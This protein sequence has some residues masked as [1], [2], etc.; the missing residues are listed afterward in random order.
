MSNY[1]DFLNVVSKLQ[2]GTTFEITVEW[3][4]AQGLTVN[5]NI[6]KSW[7]HSFANDYSKYGC[8]CNGTGSD[9]HH[10]YTKI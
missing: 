10:N 9:N 7:G 2:S 6:V 1:N 4:T 8:S 3:C 5:Q